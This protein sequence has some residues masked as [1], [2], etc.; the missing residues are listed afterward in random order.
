MTVIDLDGMGR[1]SDPVAAE[2]AEKRFFRLFLAPI[3]GIGI[4]R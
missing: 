1:H 3:N 4:Y 2:L